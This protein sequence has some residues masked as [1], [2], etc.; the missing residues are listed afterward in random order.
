M[1]AVPMAV[2]FLGYDLGLLAVA[3]LIVVVAMGL[4][5]FTA[6]FGYLRA[7]RVAVEREIAEEREL[8]AGGRN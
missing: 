1:L 6:T 5:F 7:K 4:P 8:E 3:V 2:T